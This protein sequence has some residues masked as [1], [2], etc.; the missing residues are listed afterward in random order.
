MQDLGSR[1]ILMAQ[2]MQKVSEIEG[3]TLLHFRLKGV[4][5][6]K[7]LVSRDFI[8]PDFPL[9][10]ILMKYQCGNKGK[11]PVIVQSRL[12]YPNN[13]YPYGRKTL[14][15]L[16]DIADQRYVEGTSWKDLGD[17]FYERYD[18]SVENLKRAIIRVNVAFNR[19]LA[20]G[21]IQSL[22]IVE[23]RLGLRESES[24][25][26]WERRSFIAL[27]LVYREILFSGI[28][29]IGILGAERANLVIS[30]F[31]LFRK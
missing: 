4:D 11:G 18:F 15:V 6:R 30:D 23:W 29:G 3:I 19:L 5:Y 7:K 10:R 27:S 28:C 20:V 8:Y 17:I 16:E 25:G 14:E 13:V 24:E 22:N 21:I 26:E 2:A 1:K 9:V 31:D 12:I